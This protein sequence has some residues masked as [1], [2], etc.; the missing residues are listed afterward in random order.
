MHV[1]VLFPE[2]KPGGIIND[3]VPAPDSTRGGEEWW[4]WRNRE[5]RVAPVIGIFWFSCIPS[6][7]KGAT[8]RRGTSGGW[9]WQ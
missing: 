8:S 1:Q 2:E 5:S 6:W 7:L 3:V 9:R 4:W